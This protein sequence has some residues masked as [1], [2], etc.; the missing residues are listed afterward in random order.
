MIPET[1]PSG[2]GGTSTAIHDK[3]S[4]RGGAGHFKMASNIFEWS[5]RSWGSVYVCESATGVYVYESLMNE[6]QNVEWGQ[7]C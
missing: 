1:C 6:D 7:F 4:A 2:R 3:D 5:G